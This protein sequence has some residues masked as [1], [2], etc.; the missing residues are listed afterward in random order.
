M[1]TYYVSP[2]GNDSNN[3][4]GPDA[5]NGTNAPFLTPGKVFN[6]G[7]PVLPGD[8]V[9]FGPGYYLNA[10]VTPIT[11]IGSAGSPT[12]FIGDPSNKKGF[13]DGSGNLLAPA[14]V[15]WTT[16]TSANTLDGQISSTSHLINGATNGG[17]GLQFFDMVMEV[18]MNS[19]TQEVCANLSGAA[20]Q[21][22]LFDRCRL[23]GVYGVSYITGI[24]TASRNLIVRRCIGLNGFGLTQFNLSSAAATADANLNILVESNLCLTASVTAGITLGSGTGNVAG[25]IAF[26]GNT[27]ASSGGGTVYTFSATASKVSTVNPVTIEGNHILLGYVASGGTLGAIVDNGYNRYHCTGN[28]PYL[29][30][31]AAGTSINEPAPNLVL[32]DLVAWGLAM[33]RND[34]LG[35]TDAAL[36]AQIDSAWSNTDADIRGRTV[37]PWGAGASIGCWEGSPIVQD[38]SSAIT[39]GGANSAKLTGQGEFS[40]YL[41][42]NAVA[43]TISII[44]KSTSYGGTSWPSMVIVANGSIGLA[45]DTTVAATSA[46]QAT[47]S[48]TVT[49]T[50][51]GVV[52]IR[53]ISQSSSVSSVTY[54]D[55]ASRSP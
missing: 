9:Y 32:P 38:T 29:N 34:F 39:G 17:D 21:N 6:T 52:E 14:L 19:A 53:L 41:P 15:W 45:S 8:T 35:W 4:L 27:I 33:P 42:V 24:P 49:P 36:A 16:R 20:N 54:F 1:T 37:R 30:C 25:G 7:S 18:K 47:L 43:T 31:T 10:P 50:V 28:T 22:W 12:S 11:S 13:K 5:S 46:A 44:T 23:I 48:A 26:K 40:F 2:N 3:G 55:S 51:A